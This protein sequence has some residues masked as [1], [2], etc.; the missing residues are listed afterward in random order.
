METASDY[1]AASQMTAVGHDPP[2]RCYEPQRKKYRMPA[3]SLLKGAPPLVQLMRLGS[4]TSKTV[5]GIRP[6]GPTPQP[7]K[8]MEEQQRSPQ[9]AAAAAAASGWLTYWRLAHQ[10]STV[11]HA[12]SPHHHQSLLLS[13]AAAATPGKVSPIHPSA[14]L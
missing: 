6:P 2:L 10:A 9:A 7:L 5:G 1:A 12:Y 4:S 13:G 3:L 14:Q 8:Q 11:G